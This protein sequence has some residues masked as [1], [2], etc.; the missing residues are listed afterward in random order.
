MID[1]RYLIVTGILASALYALQVAQLFFEI[2][3]VLVHYGGAREGWTLSFHDLFTYHPC[4]QTILRPQPAESE[5]RLPARGDSFRGVDSRDD[6]TTA[7]E[8]Q[9]DYYMHA[10]DAW[11]KVSMKDSDGQDMGP[12]SKLGRDRKGVKRIIEAERELYDE[13]H[14]YRAPSY[15][16]C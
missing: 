3:T 12:R 15:A 8:L 7:K 16:S 4:T 9:Y 1:T 14:W 5:V 2:A 11:S 13:H 10:K 6:K